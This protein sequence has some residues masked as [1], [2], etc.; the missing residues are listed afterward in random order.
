MAEIANRIQMATRF[1]SR[2]DRLNRQQAGEFR[3]LLGT[4]PDPKRVP[5]SFWDRVAKEQQ[6]EA[7]ALLL[8]IFLLSYD[9]HRY[10]RDDEA[11]PKENPR[12]D[13]AA[14][15]WA[16]NRSVTLAKEWKKHSLDI[17]NEKG[18]AWEV[19]SKEGADIVK[20]DVDELVN[21]IFGPSRSRAIAY[22]ETQQAMVSGGESGVKHLG[23]KVTRY[24]AHGKH[25]PAGHSHA[26]KLP[27]PVCT[28]LEGKPES[29]W[30]GIKPPAHPHCDCYVVYVDQDGFL[31]GPG[32]PG[33]A[34]GVAWKR[35]QQ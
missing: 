14:E 15:R 6:D 8:L 28:D 1:Q 21:R 32:D 31:V 19:K 34:P 30:K 17:V 18:Q 11:P 4:P 10:A 26:A 25:R 23:L 16:A 2:M 3:R 22:H 24:W 5:Q 20:R 12:R 27:C 7:A 29:Q 9:T 13:K 35:R 33:S